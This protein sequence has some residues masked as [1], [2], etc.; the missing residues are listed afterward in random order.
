MSQRKGDA[1]DRAEEFDA[2]GR[3]AD[4]HD[5]VG[6]RTAQFLDRRC[7]RSEACERGGDAREVGVDMAP[8]GPGAVANGAGWP[9]V[10]ACEAE[11]P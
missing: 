5:V 9:R 6:A 4:P 10:P 2:D 3:C 7:R 1:G 8:F 11:A